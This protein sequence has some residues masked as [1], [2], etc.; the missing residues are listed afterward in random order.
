MYTDDYFNVLNKSLRAHPRSIPAF[1]IDLER[2]DANLRTLKA[3]LPPGRDF[4]L[5]VKSLPCLK[6]IDY[7]LKYMKTDRLMVFHQPFLSKLHQYYGD[8]VD[9][10]LGKP[11]PIDNASYFYQHLALEAMPPKVQWLV[12]NEDRLQNYIQLARKYNHRLRINLEID[13]G[14]HRGGFTSLD[15]LDLALSILE[16]VPDYIELSGLMGYDPHLAKI[17]SFLKKPQRSQ[18]QAFDF[19]HQCKALIQEKH[20]KLWHQGL[21]FNAGGSPSLHF[22]QNDSPANELAAGSCLLKPSDFDNKTLQDYSPACF[23]STP[24]LKKEKHTKIPGLEK[25]S[26]ISSGFSPKLKNAYFI[27]GGYW[28]ADYYYPKDAQEN[29]LFGSSTNQSLINTKNGDLQVGDSI[30]LRPHQSES[31]MPQFEEILVVR[32]EKIVGQWAPLRGE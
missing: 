26:S 9:L 20:P 28:K 13:V 25:I 27:Y 1:I 23:I 19:Y 14:L 6:L 5:V 24:I 10:L 8:Q 21:T 17:P 29:Q 3:Q 2:L 11:M 15:E 16:N 22:H 30:F 4:R 31:V 12:D 18:Q 7:V 32:G